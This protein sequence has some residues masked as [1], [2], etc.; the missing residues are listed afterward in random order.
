M[1][2]NLL[3]LKTYRVGERCTLNLLRVETFS[4]GCGVKVRRMECHLRCC[5]RH[6]TMAQNYEVRH[7]NALV[8]LDYCYVNILSLPHAGHEP[9]TITTSVLGLQNHDQASKT[10]QM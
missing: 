4:H 7:Q 2:S 8:Q 10:T 1:S 5:P 3:P 9:G 6:L